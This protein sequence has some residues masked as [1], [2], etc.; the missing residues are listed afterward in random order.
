M[1]NGDISIRILTLIFV[2]IYDP[3]IFTEIKR[4]EVLT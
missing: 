3:D 2:L 1:G 4:K